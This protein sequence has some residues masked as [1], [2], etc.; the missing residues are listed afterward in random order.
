M[1]RRNYRYFILFINST[2]VLCL[3]VFVCSIFQIKLKLDELNSAGKE[4]N[5]WEAIRETPAAMALVVYV[6]LCVW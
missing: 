6:F 5:V 1:G 2:T 3:Y 4:A